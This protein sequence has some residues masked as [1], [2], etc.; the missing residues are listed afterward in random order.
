MRS[1]AALSLMLVLL[2]GCAS[3]DNYF[4]LEEYG[5]GWSLKVVDGRPTEREPDGSFRASWVE[6]ENR[7]TKLVGITET[8]GGDYYIVSTLYLEV[9]AQGNVVNG[10]LKRVVLPEFEQRSYYERT[11]PWFK[12]LEG[13]CHLNADLTGRLS[14]RCES[15]YE[16]DA[17]ILPMDGL[18]V[19]KPE[20]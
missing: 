13:T 8:K 10:L 7:S 12:V 4:R 6:G 9:D 17:E 15:D 11:A 20:K 18:T 14:V 16:F 2:V 1:V 19:R 5:E 3:S